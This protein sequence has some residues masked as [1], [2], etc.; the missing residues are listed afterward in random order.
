MTEALGGILKFGFEELSATQ[1]EACHSLWNRGSEKVFRNRNP[2]VSIV[3]LDCEQSERLKR[4]RTENRLK[5]KPSKRDVEF[6]DNLLR[7]EDKTYRMN[8][9]EG[10]YPE[11]NIFRIENTN[12]TAIEVAENIVNHFKQL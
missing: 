6:S 11:M 10:E 12:K 9:V 1:I 3:E 7:N 2:K 5:H 4:N 8:S